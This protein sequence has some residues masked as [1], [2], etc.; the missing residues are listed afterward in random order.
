M[1]NFARLCHPVFVRPWDWQARICVC[2]HMCSG[3]FTRA[4]LSVYLCLC[5]SCVL[6]LFMALNCMFSWPSFLDL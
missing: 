1:H 6:Y 2:A 3:I 4:R 5:L